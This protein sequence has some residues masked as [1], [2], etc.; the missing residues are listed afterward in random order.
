MIHL[1]LSIFNYKICIRTI[2]IGLFF[3]TQTGYTQTDAETIQKEFGD[4]S[5]VELIDIAKAEVN[6]FGRFENIIIGCPTWNI[7]ELQDD[8]NSFFDEL[9]NIDFSHKKVAYFG[10]GDQFGY[11]D[12]FQDAISLLET[13]IHSPNSPAPLSH[14]P[15]QVTYDVPLCLPV[16]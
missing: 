8:W 15:L 1:L 5:V 7:G 6:N 14:F 2:K 16:S 12:S 10:S 3:G 9:E 11:A 13:K 4:D